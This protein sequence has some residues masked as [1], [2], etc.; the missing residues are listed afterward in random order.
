MAETKQS[1]SMDRHAELMEYASK[2][3]GRLRQIADLASICAEQVGTGP[4]LSNV[5]NG[6]VTIAGIANEK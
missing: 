5:R 4:L 2:L 6:F 1:F 3:E